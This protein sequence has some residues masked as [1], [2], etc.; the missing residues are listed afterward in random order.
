MREKIQKEIEKRIE[1]MEF[2]MV[3]SA[4]DFSDI[5]NQDASNKALSRLEKEGKIKRIIRGLYYVPEFSELIGE[6]SLPRIDMIAEAIARKFNW[7]IAPSGD[8]ALNVL[9]L[10]TQ[11]P[12][13]W[14][15]VSDG[16]NRE[17]DIDG[18]AL[19]FKR[20]KQ[21][22]ISGFHT[23][24]VTVIQAIRGIGKDYISSKHKTIL[25][26][27]LSE[28]DKKIVLEESRIASS[29]IAEIIKEICKGE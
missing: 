18:I 17:Y 1:K 6:Y 11:V 12:N 9:G 23:I 8:T 3:L 28:E 26:N 29:W 5:S 2:G 14:N 19:T 13:T 20:I 7:S 21:S 22:E 4:R 16:P 27:N 10:S 15:Y 24:T 25:K